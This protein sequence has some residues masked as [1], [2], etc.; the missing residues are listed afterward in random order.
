MPFGLEAWPTTGHGAQQRPPRRHRQIGGILAWR[1]LRPAV[2]LRRSARA[3]GARR[4]VGVSV[5][6]ALACARPRHRRGRSHGEGGKPDVLVE[7]DGRNVALRAE[8]GTLALP[9][10][11]RANYSV[12][13]WVLADGDDRDAA[14]VAAMSP[15]RCD[16]LGCIGK[17]KGKTLALIRH[18]PTGR[19]LPQGA[20]AA[21]RQAGASRG[22]GLCEG[23]RRRRRGR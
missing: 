15:F 18:P 16:L 13:N 22:S 12:D 20:G 23:P 2:D 6:D 1:R 9:P 3:H 21:N 10:A 11:T 14:D 7:R 5:A 17:V 19:G 4:T 8:H